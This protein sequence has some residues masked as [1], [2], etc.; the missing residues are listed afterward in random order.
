MYKNEAIIDNIEIATPN[1]IKLQSVT[2]NVQVGDMLEFRLDPTA[3]GGTLEYYESKPE[4]AGWAWAG[5]S[6][7]YP[8]VGVLVGGGNTTVTLMY[9]LLSTAVT[10]IRARI[11]THNHD[12]RCHISEKRPP[13]IPLINRYD[14]PDGNFDAV[15]GTLDRERT[16]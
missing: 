11:L 5:H 9:P 12:I 10:D 14:V 16:R 1:I 2:L 6:M 13:F 8:V 7:V 15:A 3:V 4:A